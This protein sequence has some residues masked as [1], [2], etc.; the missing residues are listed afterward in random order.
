MS[1]IWGLK[2]TG[3]HGVMTVD[4]VEA[5]A[6]ANAGNGAPA[7]KANVRAAAQFIM[8]NGAVNGSNLLHRGKV[9]RHYTHGRGANHVTLF[10]TNQDGLVASIIGIGSHRNPQG[11]TYDLDWSTPGWAIG[12]VVDL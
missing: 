1:I 10:F 3:K 11:A 5:F 12:R 7:W 6:I 4:D 2:Q 9:V 8:A